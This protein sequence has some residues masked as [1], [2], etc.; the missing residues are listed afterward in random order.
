[1]RKT[2]LVLAVAGLVA[3]TPAARPAAPLLPEPSFSVPGALEGLAVAGSRVA[4]SAWCEVRVATLR[5]ARKPE[6]PP[7]RVRGL[8]CDDPDS[9]SFFVSDLWLGRR[10]LAA[11]LIQAESP[12]GAEYSVW[13]G[14]LPSGPLRL[15]GEEWGWRDDNPDEPS[16]GCAGVVVA[17]GGVIASTEVPNRLGDSTEP[18]CPSNGTTSIA[19]DGA[20]R[21]RTTVRGSW[22]LLATDGKRLALSR[23]DARGRPTGQLSLVRLDGKPVATPRMRPATVKAASSG[24]LAPEG[25][26]LQTRA[27]IAGPGWAIRGV[28]TATV[29][30]GRVLYLRGNA[31]RGRRIRDGVDRK[32]LTLPRASEEKLVAAGSFGLAL[33]VQTGDEEASRTSV[34]RIGWRVIDAVLPLR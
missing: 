23:L 16:Y 31:L 10:S 4:V 26:V 17:G 11:E 18:A 29:A 8:P 2:G 19:L 12:H 14:P 21:G 32:V 5:A 24:W 1:M 34:Y 15:L 7:A 22:T 33:A 3:V 13:K 20:A 9:G 25:L 27:G 30:Y 28:F 6:A